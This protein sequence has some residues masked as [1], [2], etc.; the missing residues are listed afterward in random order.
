MEEEEEEE[1][2]LEAPKTSKAEPSESEETAEEMPES[3]L[4]H[5][6][7]EL[8]ASLANPDDLAMDTE[9]ETE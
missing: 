4:N 8:A 9:S 2:D 1:E 3:E 5:I 6:L 7:K